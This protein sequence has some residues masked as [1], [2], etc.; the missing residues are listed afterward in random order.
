ML[1]SITPIKHNN[2][3][4]FTTRWRA[5]L[6]TAWPLIVANSFWNLQLTIDR[7]FLA[8]Y[9]TAALGA[10]MAVMGVFWVPMAL[11]QGTANYVVAF[12]AQY[13]GAKE[14]NNIGKS[15]WQSIYV[16][17]FGGIA[18]L[19][20]NFLSDP[21]FKL[22]GHSHVTQ[23]LET[24][25]FNAL[26]WSALPTALVAA[27]SGLFTGLEQTRAV[28]MINLVGLLLNALLDWLM[29][30]GNGGLPAMGIAGAGY[31]T[32]LATYGAAAFGLALAFKKSNRVRFGLTNS[33]QLN[34]Q[35]IAKF[36]RF[37][38]PS[39]LQWAMEGMAFTVFLII[40]GNTAQGDLALAATSISV[41]IML[42]SVLPSL[43]MAQTVMSLVGKYIGEKNIK[44]ARQVTWDGA[45]ISLIYI[46]CVGITLIFFPHIHLAWF[47]N[48]SD[49][50]LW[51]QTAALAEKILCIVAFF[52]L[53]DSAYLN[54]SFALKGAGD[55]KF[56]SALAMVLPWPI[57]VLPA[58][59]FRNHDQAAIVA[60][61]FAAA[62]SVTITAT[63]I[64]RFQQGK[65]ETM[66]VIG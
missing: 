37:G 33:W 34:R 21:F 1:E 36:L 28:L 9:S 48:N 27:I 52:T 42:L 39:G 49:P 46:A 56:V 51:A 64:W 40:M 29:I 31:A 47:Q 45:R 59:I 60:W 16:S 4:S 26:A 55:T 50:A 30:F 5:L 18:F 54:V 38:I 63:F 13:L 20:L 12:V 10:A 6:A 8:D 17:L 3:Q 44:A 32:A 24:S 15:F 65:W 66:N 61:Y 23:G 43:G 57:M 22:V 14:E 19:A 62:Y 58:W 25:Y 41:T 35:L 11:L 2:N 53:F 7:I